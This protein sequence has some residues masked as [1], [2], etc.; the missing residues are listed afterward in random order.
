MTSRFR[1]LALPVA[2]LLLARHGEVEVQFVV[3]SSGRA[4]EATLEVLAAT[5]AELEESVRRALPC[6]RFRP[7]TV[8]GR[9]VRQLVEKPFSFILPR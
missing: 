1:L 2:L 9:P 6:M 3:D 4:D 5:H 7:A 8:D